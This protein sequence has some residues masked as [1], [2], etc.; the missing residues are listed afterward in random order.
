MTDYVHIKIR[1]TRP[2]FLNNSRRFLYYDYDDEGNDVNDM[3]I[4]PCRHVG[5]IHQVYVNDW[6]KPKN[7]DER[8][9]L[10]YLQIF[11]YVVVEPK[12]KLNFNSLYG[13]SCRRIYQSI[14]DDTK[15]LC[16][17]S[18]REVRFRV[19]SLPL[20]KKVSLDVFMGNLRVQSV[21]H[22]ELPFITR[23]S[24]CS[25]GHENST[26]G[27]LLEDHFCSVCGADNF[28]YHLW[29]RIFYTN[30]FYK[31]FINF[32]DKKFVQYVKYAR[33]PFAWLYD[34]TFAWLYDKIEDFFLYNF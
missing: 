24:A 15:P 8:M 25:N 11:D 28:E 3:F 30:C 22:D 17:W 18:A 21:P 23:K 26:E 7:W 12:P 10:N 13:K 34:K 1:N 27:Y 31:R 14:V 6:P 4:I 20:P 2:R 5:R 32:Y 9:L 29:R 19:F 16:L 33:V